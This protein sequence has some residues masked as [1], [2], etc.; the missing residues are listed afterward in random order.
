MSS[1]EALSNI[2]DNINQFI[3]SNNERT[4]VLEGERT[5]TRFLIERMNEDLVRLKIKPHEDDYVTQLRMLHNKVDIITNKTNEMKAD[6]QQQY[7]KLEAMLIK[8][9]ITLKHT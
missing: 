8:I 1:E 4:Q 6:Y 7:D 9:I 3:E 2:I 5:C